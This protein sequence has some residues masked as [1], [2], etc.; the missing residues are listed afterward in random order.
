[1]IA[2]ITVQTTSMVVLPCVWLGSR[3]G[4][5]RYLMTIQASSDQTVM[6]TADSRPNMT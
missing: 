5:S 4:R 1:M 2:G 6:S 3:S